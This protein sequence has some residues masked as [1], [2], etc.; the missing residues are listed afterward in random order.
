MGVP[1]GHCWLVGDKASWSMDSTTFGP[2]PLGA[3]SKT[4]IL[5]KEQAHVSE[6]NRY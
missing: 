2:I 4:S 5:P 1:E 3:N 6:E